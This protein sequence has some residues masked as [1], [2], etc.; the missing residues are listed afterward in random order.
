MPG[1]RSPGSISAI[2]NGLDQQVNLEARK[3]GDGQSESDKI[4][5][6]ALKAR[7]ARK[8]EKVIQTA[9]SRVERNPADAQIKQFRKE[10]LE[11]PRELLEKKHSFNK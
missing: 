11:V 7:G 1:G 6:A 5:E 2:Y 8:Q 3:R 10:G 9:K 4:N